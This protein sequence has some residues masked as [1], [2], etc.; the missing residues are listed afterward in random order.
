M[1]KNKCWFFGD[2]FCHPCDREY[3]KYWWGNY[4]TSVLGQERVL[5]SVGGA[6]IQ[7]TIHRL[8]ENL[9]NIQPGDTVFISYTAPHRAYFN[10]RSVTFDRGFADNVVNST[11][12]TDEE[13]TVMKH[14]FLKLYHLEDYLKLF[15]W[16]VQNIQQIMIPKLI[17]R[18]VTVHHF[19][20]I[21]KPDVDV[22]QSLIVAKEWV[23][24]LAKEKG[25]VAE[26]ILQTPHHFGYP[27]VGD[28]NKEWSDIWVN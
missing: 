26:D 17:Q 18:G 1:S 9:D 23:E 3:N 21:E 4:V 28:L 8:H 14:Y 5:K 16:I 19:Y 25:F 15:T 11:Y 27:D 6:S 2:S 10:G 13:L 24:N 12:F 7:H 22:D 20:S